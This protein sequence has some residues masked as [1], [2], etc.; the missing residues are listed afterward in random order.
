MSG[1]FAVCKVERGRVIPGL[2]RGSSHV[3][4]RPAQPGA[5]VHCR[6]APSLRGLVVCP[7]LGVSR[8][9]GAGLEGIQP[10]LM[11]LRDGLRG[12][13]GDPPGRRQGSACRHV[14]CPLLGSQPAVVAGPSLSWKPAMR[15]K[16]RRGRRGDRPGPRFLALAEEGRIAGFLRVFRLGGEHGPARRRPGRRPAPRGAQPGGGP[17]VHRLAPHRSPRR[18]GLSRIRGQAR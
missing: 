4:C 16:L 14:S 3:P 12:R 1:L 5:R 13:R 7:G 2:R 15:E 11:R 8:E 10:W 6:C 9:A 17:G 18:A